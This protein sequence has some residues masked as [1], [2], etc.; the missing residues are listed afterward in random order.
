MLLPSNVFA[1]KQMQLKVWEALSVQVVMILFLKRCLITWPM[2]APMGAGDLGFGTCVT[3]KLLCFNLF[4]W[5]CQMFY[6]Q[7]SATVL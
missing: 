3:Q 2:L 7:V 6:L 1:D 4:K 5:S